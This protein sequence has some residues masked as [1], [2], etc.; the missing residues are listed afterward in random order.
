[1]ETSGLE[2]PTPGLQ[3]YPKTTPK[4]QFSPGFPAILPLESGSASPFLQSQFCPRNS[5]SRVRKSGSLPVVV[6]T[7]IL[8]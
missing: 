8:R 2:P 4:S 6:N 5:G 3:K 7:P 1:V